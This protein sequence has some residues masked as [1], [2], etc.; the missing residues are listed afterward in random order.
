MTDILANNEDAPWTLDVLLDQVRHSDLVTDEMGI[1]QHHE[2]VRQHKLRFLV[3]VA[4]SVT[5]SPTSSP[6]TCS[7]TRSDVST[8]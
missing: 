5:H 1:D 3:P 6:R 4:G 8:W 2:G 7:S